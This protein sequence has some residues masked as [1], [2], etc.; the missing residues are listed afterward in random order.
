[1]S[2][3]AALA[4]AALGASAAG[5][6]NSTPALAGVGG[7]GGHFGIGGHGGTGVGGAGGIAQVDAG[8]DS[9][10]PSP[11][12]TAPA[13]T[14][15]AWVE[16][17]PPVGQDGFRVT[18]AF[19]AGPN[20]LFFAGVTSDQ[21]NPPSN[22]RVLRW[23]AGCWTVELT[24]TPS[25]GSQA[26]TP[27]VNGTSASDVWATG[28]DLLFHRDA[29]GWTRFADES[30]R[31]MVHQPPSFV[32]A[33]ELNRVRT[34]AP[35]QIWV[36]ASN[37]M[38]RWNGQAWAA[39]NFDDATYPNASGSIAYFFK[40]IW[41]DSG[42]SVWVASAS[43]QIG[44]TMDQG[45]VHHFDGAN[46]THTAVGLGGVLSIWHAGTP[47]WLATPTQDVVGGQQVSRTIRRFDGTSAPTVPVAGI[48]PT[49]NL[50]LVTLFARGAGDVWASGGDVAH[51]DGQ[52]WSLISDAPAA[53]RNASDDKN[54][55]VT[56]DA[57]SIWLSTP[58]PRFFRKAD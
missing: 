37:N 8:A 2:I 43:D 52:S 12:C 24:I 46:W 9:G 48:T 32:G 28:G 6:S 7:G 14:P 50:Y 34:V 40:D 1:M 51:F 26:L 20:D 53:A 29:Q 27:S 5:C 15:G 33:I 21:V 45:F 31:N 35:N 38:L 41:I 17:T 44:N 16:V 3:R 58:G 57:T 49:Q 39:F 22:P 4:C 30:W 56:G 23:A 11:V 54:T 19:A 47:Y 18:D 42:T 36:A 25:A 55:Y 13:A 10:S